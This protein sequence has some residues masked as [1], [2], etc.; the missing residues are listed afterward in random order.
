MNLFMNRYLVLIGGETSIEAETQVDNADGAISE[1]PSISVK[2][3]IEDDSNIEEK[4][5]GT[6]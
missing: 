2:I 4:S 5:K 6:S 1:D 3:K